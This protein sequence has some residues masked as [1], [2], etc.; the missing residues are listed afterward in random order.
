MMMH[1][2]LPSPLDNPPSPRKMLAKRKRGSKMNAAATTETMSQRTAKAEQGYTFEYVDYKSLFTLV[3][4]L[5]FY[6]KHIL[7]IFPII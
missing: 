6:F 1:A 3:S 7:I 2:G 4:I 5:F